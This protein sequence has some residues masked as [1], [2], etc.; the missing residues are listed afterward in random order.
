MS[1]LND[2]KKLNAY[3][4]DM[5]PAN[6]YIGESKVAGW[7]AATFSGQSP[8]AVDCDYNVPP[9]ALVIE[10]ECAQ[11]VGVWGTNLVT[12]GDFSNGTTGWSGYSASVAASSNILTCTGSGEYAYA[13]ANSP[14]MTV[15]AGHKYYTAAYMS[16][17]VAG[18][19]LQLRVTGSNEIVFEV[20]T[21]PAD[22][23]HLIRGVATYAATGAYNIIPRVAFASTAEATGAIVKVKYV[24]AI[25]L[26][27]AFGAG[28]EPTAEQMDAYLAAYPNSWFDGSALI[29]TDGT[30]NSPSPTYPAPITTITG[31]L[32]IT[33]A[34]GNLSDTATA[35]LGAVELC[36]LPDGTKDEYDAVAG[37]LT[38]RVHKVV[39]DGTESGW[40]GGSTATVGKYRY[41]ITFTPLKA[42]GNNA[43]IANIYC[44]RFV[45]VNPNQ[46]YENIDGVGDTTGNNTFYFYYSEITNS[47]VAAW[48]AWLAANPVTVYYK[49]ATPY[50]IQLTPDL[51]VVR[52]GIKT[53]SI[54]ADVA[55]TISATVKAMD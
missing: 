3:S 16:S 34:N 40:W 10:G 18:K 39:F 7:H 36:S 22:I 44:D 45:P 4:L 42:N 12:N 47:S 32:S 43:L 50:T 31:D 29:T 27:A 5:Q 55:P 35:S 20:F 25:D 21:A 15:Y 13:G 52:T 48:T 8:L 14:N 19:T 53:L 23:F 30:P 28:N 33:G 24:L 37:L 9:D 6:V 17:S 41:G 49:L 11:T 38:K 54:G 2:S 1:V 26:T 51:P 46:T